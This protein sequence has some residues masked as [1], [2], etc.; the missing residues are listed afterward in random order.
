MA[1]P[2]HKPL[3]WGL[4]VQL[5]AREMREGLA[6]FRIF[7]LCLILGISTIAAVGSLSASLVGGMAAQGQSIL[8]GDIDFRL[9][10]RAAFDDERDWLD[11]Q[12]SVSEVAT[13]RAMIRHGDEAMLAEA[14]SVD[15]AYP[16]YGTVK[17]APAM[18][19][20]A[21]SAAPEAMAGGALYPAMA[22]KGL[23]DRLQLSIGDVVSLGDIRLRLVAE[24]VQEPDRTS[25][26]FPL[27]PRL[28][29]SHATL[30]AAGLLQPGS[31]VNFHYRVKL[32]DNAEVAE[33]Q[34]VSARAAER[35]PN[36]GWRIRDRADASP[37]LRRFVERLGL[38]LTLVGLTALVVGGVGVGNAITAYIEKRRE[39]I[40]VMK[41]LGASGR[42]VFRIYAAQIA[43]LTL[44]ATAIGLTIGAATPWLL[45]ALAGALLP[46]ELHVALFPKPLLA[47]A[48]FGVL[49]AAGF[50]LWPLGRAEKTPVTGLFRNDAPQAAHRP[51]AFYIVAIGLCFAGL[52]ALALFIS[53]RR[54]V[55]LWFGL[56]VGLSYLA[57]R[58]TAGVIVW[59]AG[60]AAVLVSEGRPALRLALANIT[61]PNAPVQAVVLSIGLSV[62]LLSAISMV[63]G[64]IN[65]QIQGDLPARTPSFFFLD[66]QPTQI[67]GFL[68]AA[69]TFGGVE[70]VETLPMLRGQIMAINE[71][72][73]R[74]LTPPPEAAWI[75]RGDRG[76]TYSVDPPEGGAL[77]EGE[78]WSPDYNG[79][80]LISFDAEIARAYGIGV[81]DRVQV[82]V[83]GRPLTA[84][85]ANLRHV[86][87]ES[88]GM[89]FVMVFSPHP[90][91]NAPHSFLATLVMAADK[92]PEFARMVAS[93]YPNVTIIRVKEA[94]E[95]FAAI[96]NNL[97]LAVRAMSGVTLLAGVLVLAGAMA[98]GHRARVYD[99]VVMKVLGATR[100]RILLAYILEYALM[101]LAAALIAAAVGTLASWGLVAGA[102]QAE[103]VFLPVTLGLTV[104]GA[105]SLT[106]ILGLLGTFNALGVAVAPVLRAQ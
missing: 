79:P 85:I 59:L 33:V 72:L 22:E 65:R 34:A 19:M 80:P 18:S 87:W 58:A 51:S 73:S 82:N 11:K 37:S 91:K 78:W 89:N 39:S 96:L 16:L 95:T 35:F 60:R 5:A 15:A 41:A 40:A 81:G 23:F 71:T 8:G 50:A 6:G 88:G 42:F 98:T 12:G 55:A 53:E 27:A 69:E 47:A 1:E 100:R 20:S 36:A 75:L 74:D 61:R 97:G 3:G 26:G 31:L 4:A 29:V 32:P 64:N 10:H 52:L 84:E 101:G 76:L 83:L 28:M 24:L 46:V 105:V 57:L 99:A 30:R 66:I 104:I 93:D 44:V 43:G 68:Q 103:W 25:G 38:F 48:G 14:K 13:M 77:V 86:D 49:A 92:E 56:G 106:I 62:A 70:Q 102:M 90:L 9:V 45:Q 17:T 67:D 2:T 21:L 54:D 7:L 94:M 63:D